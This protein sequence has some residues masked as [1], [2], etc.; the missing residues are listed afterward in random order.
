[1]DLGIKGLSS[2][3]EFMELGEFLEARVEVL[4]PALSAES[5]NMGRYQYLQKEPLL[6]QETR[7]V[8]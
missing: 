6:S 7:V 1:L 4:I 5:S 3:P 8:S 2:E